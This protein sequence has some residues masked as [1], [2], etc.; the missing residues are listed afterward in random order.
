[1]ISK[2]LSTKLGIPAIRKGKL[3]VY[4]RVEAST[5]DRELELL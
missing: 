5:Q 2:P 1:M 3:T 4:K